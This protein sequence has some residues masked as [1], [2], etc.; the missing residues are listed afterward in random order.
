MGGNFVLKSAKKMLVLAFTSAILLGGCSQNAAPPKDKTQ[1][2]PAPMEETAISTT[3]STFAIE[4]LYVDSCGGCH[5]QTRL[6]ALGPN[7]LPDRLFTSMS[8]EEI[9]D[10]IKN[11]RAGTPMP[12]FDT[13]SKDNSED[14]TIKQL[15]EYLKTPVALEA[16][17]WSLEDAKAT[18]EVVNDESTLPD[19]PTAWDPG[20]IEIGDLMVAMERETRKYAVLDGKNHELLG[21]IDGSYRTHTIQF[22]PSDTPEGRFMYGIGRDGWLFKVD[23]YSFK[24]VRKVRVGLDSRGVAVT[25]DGEYIAVTNYLP[26]TVVIVNKNLE[27]LK[28]IPTYAVDPDGQMVGIDGSQ[29]RAAAILDTVI[30]GKDMFVV[31]LKE[32]GHVWVIDT[33]KEVQKKASQSFMTLAV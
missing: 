33:S 20:K 13:V 25:R 11:G 28:V 4:K 8:E 27:P 12:P 2:P 14:E 17:T 9:F 31:A 19:T 21:H 24:T 22:G 23:M 26:G 30:D 1:V 6:G 5:G 15:I 18:L 3:A 10:I 32:A 16:Q 7:L 29:S